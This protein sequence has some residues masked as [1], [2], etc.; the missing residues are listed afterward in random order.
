MCGTQE[1][2]DSGWNPPLGVEKLPVKKNILT[3]F[4]NY[5]AINDGTP[6][7]LQC[8]VVLEAPLSKYPM[9]K[10]RGLIFLGADTFRKV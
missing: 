6:G 4:N 10:S 8:Q 5:S 7:H 9:I 1:P 3:I 2:M